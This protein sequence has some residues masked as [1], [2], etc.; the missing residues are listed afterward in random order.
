MNREHPIRRF[1]G[2]TCSV[3]ARAFR[4]GRP[5]SLEEHVLRFAIADRDTKRPI[6]TLETGAGITQ[7]DK[8]NYEAKVPASQ[9]SSLLLPENEY[10][11][12]VEISLFGGEDERYPLLY[13]PLHLIG[14][15]FS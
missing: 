9:M 14:S 12:E 3:R 13:G 10:W 5:V 8:G 4:N 11:Y 6:I 2:K 7:D 15:P 1:R